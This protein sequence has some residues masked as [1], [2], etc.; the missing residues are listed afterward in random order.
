MLGLFTGMSLMS[1][2]ESLLWIA[3]MAIKFL[4]CGDKCLE[5]N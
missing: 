3:R 2:V 5:T 1:L 4:P